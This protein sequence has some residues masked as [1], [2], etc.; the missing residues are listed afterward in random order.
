[1]SQLQVVPVSI[2]NVLMIQLSSITLPITAL[3][4]GQ[5]RCHATD[6]SEEVEVLHMLIVVCGYVLFAIV[7][8]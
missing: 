7:I 5:K 1:M 4:E 6:K 8:F 2:E 3:V